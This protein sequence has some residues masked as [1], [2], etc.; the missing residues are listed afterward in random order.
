MMVRSLCDDIIQVRI[1]LEDK[2]GL[3][4]KTFIAQ[5]LILPFRQ[6]DPDPCLSCSGTLLNW[7]SGL[8]EPSTAISN[9]RILLKVYPYY[10]KDLRKITVAYRIS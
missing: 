8:T 10:L 3:K 1:G 4:A 9:N 6:F 5:V 7:Q 2:T